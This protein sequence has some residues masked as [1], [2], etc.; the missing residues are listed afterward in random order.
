EV[1]ARVRLLER[2]FGAHRPHLAQD[3]ALVE[4]GVI[5]GAQWMGP[6]AGARAGPCS[7]G[8]ALDPAVRLLHGVEV[9]PGI[10]CT[11]SRRLPGMEGQAFHHRREEKGRRWP[12]PSPPPG[13]SRAPLPCRT[14]AARPPR[15]PPTP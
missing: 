9:L 3:R 10:R 4:G 2:A 12:S 5:C 7:T 14:W 8:S 1:I 11:R 6:P 15:P 13:A